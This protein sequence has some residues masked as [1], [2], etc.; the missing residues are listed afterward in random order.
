MG[1]PF[2]VAHLVPVTAVLIALLVVAD[3]PGASPLG[4]AGAPLGPGGDPA[5]VVRWLALGLL[6]APAVMVYAHRWAAAAAAMVCALG[7][8]VSGLGY[9]W[10][11]LLPGAYA[12]VAVGV[13]R[14]RPG[15]RAAELLDRR[16]VG[17]AL[18]AA[19]DRH[20]ARSG[21]G[22]TH[23]IHQ[24]PRAVPAPPARLPVIA[25]GTA[26]IGVTAVAGALAVAAPGMWRV[27]PASGCAAVVLLGTGIALLARVHGRRRGLRRLFR[28]P[29]PVRPARV[30]DQLGYL[31]VLVP[32]AD[33]RNAVEFGVDTADTWST[34]DAEDGDPRTRA[35]QLYGDPW[36]GA[37][38]AVEV[39]GRVHVPVEPVSATT[40]VA[41]DPEHG[42]PRE[43]WDDE[44]QLADPAALT[45][46]DRLAPPGQIREHR[47]APVRA[48]AS[49]TATGLG[50]AL[51]VAELAH[52]AG[53]RTSGP[54]VTAVAV[55]AAAGLEF[56]WRT[57][58]RPR[59]RWHAGGL[60]SVGAREVVR[61]PWTVDT[62]VVHDD[63]E[64]VT[65]TAGDS[66]LTVPAPGPWPFAGGGDRQRTVT[67]LV[68]ALRAARSQA[69]AMVVDGVPPP[70]P[71][72]V[73]APR[74][75]L[76]LYAA[77][78]LIV[79]GSAALVLE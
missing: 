70:P 54:A 14:H 39:D 79:A 13:A 3:V 34:W 27:E 58:L 8:A 44:E 15:R 53:W 4:A 17:A 16:P 67:E 61:E 69:F 38:V 63:E 76:V 30:V 1:R 46:R 31:H 52:L 78:V 68:A 49:T 55:A 28:D 47:P 23:H 26:A 7:W 18:A 10:R 24:A 33:D 72:L 59:L 66:V 74:R 51:A 73:A 48:W 71:P 60:A 36:P 64:S 2:P 35:A 11:D 65:V 9:G 22:G 29:Q 37:W 12:A 77:W 32:A 41:Y 56:G 25:R 57:R 75:P 6:A 50:A 19:V 42:L 45:D 20:A 40:V 5:P 62:A 43:I 21:L